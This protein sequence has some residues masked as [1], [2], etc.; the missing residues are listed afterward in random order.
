MKSFKEFLTEA[1]LTNVFKMYNG[2]EKDVETPSWYRK[3]YCTRGNIV[4]TKSLKFNLGK[5]EIILHKYTEDNKNYFYR[6]A[7]VTING[8]STEIDYTLTKKIAKKSTINSHYLQEFGSNLIFEL[9]VFLQYCKTE[10]SKDKLSLDDVINKFADC[11][12]RNNITY[13]LD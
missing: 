9:N 2:T 12:K 3:T 7:N 13:N 11:I 5:C 1:S 4:K 10:S 6:L 8:K